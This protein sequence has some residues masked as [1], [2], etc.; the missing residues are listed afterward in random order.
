[1]Q[2]YVIAEMSVRTLWHG[3]EVH[4]YSDEILQ[5]ASFTIVGTAVFIIPVSA[6]AYLAINRSLKLYRWLH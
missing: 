2:L 5:V 6:V 1:M 4:F 3:E